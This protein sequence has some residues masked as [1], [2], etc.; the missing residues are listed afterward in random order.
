[1]FSDLLALTVIFTE[2]MISSKLL[3]D[4][5][6]SPSG[7]AVSAD[8]ASILQGSDLKVNMRLPRP[9]PNVGLANNNFRD[10]AVSFWEVVWIFDEIASSHLSAPFANA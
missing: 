9:T 8:L 2:F 3:R 4:R 10:C 7:E 1:M 6:A 5:K